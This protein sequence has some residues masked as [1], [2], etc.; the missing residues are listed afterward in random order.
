[1][2]AYRTIANKES[3]DSDNKDVLQKT[4]KNTVSCTGIG[5]HTG[6]PVTL[7]LRPAPANSGIRFVRTDIRPRGVMIK[8]SWKNVV[9]TTLCT[10][11]GTKEE[12]EVTIGTIEHLMAAFAGCA[13]DN[14]LVEINGPEVPIMDGSSA[15]FVFLIEC[16]GID[17]QPIP[18]R[19]IKVLKEVKVTLENRSATLTPH[20]TFALT[21]DFDFMGRANL[22]AQNFQFSE[23]ATSFKR[24]LSK[25][26]T[27]G[28]YEDVEKLRAANLAQGS[29]LENAVVIRNSEV[30]NKEGLHYSNE[31]VRHKALDA[32]GD[33]YLMGGPLLGHFHGVRSGHHLNYLLLK[34]LFSDESNW[35]WVNIPLKDQKFDTQTVAV[36]A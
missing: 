35:E 33:L 31:F 25:A 19:A 15:P 4:L 13:I 11:I 2:T 7:I 3:N 28:F 26:R 10:K 30:L 32:V 22:P 24:D 14:A 5:A 6:A 9:N 1:M 12:P 29:S 18:R 16:A 17:T 36:N 20:D 27:F 21:F 34:E 23:N 8:A